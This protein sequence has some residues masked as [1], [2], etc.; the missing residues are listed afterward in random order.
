MSECPKCHGE[1]GNAK[2]CGCGWKEQPKRGEATPLP[3]IDCAHEMCGTPAIVKVQTKTGW[4]TLCER[5]YLEHKNAEAKAWLV[6][7]GLWCD[8]A[9]RDAEYYEMLRAKC[10]E[11]AATMREKMQRRAA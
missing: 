3:H 11:F 9:Y 4:A 2:Y 7:R 5:H 8:P 6:E 10:K 1:I